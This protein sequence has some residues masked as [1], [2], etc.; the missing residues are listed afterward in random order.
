MGTVDRVLHGRGEVSEK[1]RERILGIISEL[2]YQP[3]VLASTLASK[4]PALFAT[5]LPLPLSEEGYWTK[6]LLGIK[7][8]ISEL[9]H[10]GVR[11]EIF[12]FNQTNSE[13][14]V[15]EADKILKLKPDGVV[16]APFFKNEAVHFTEQLKAEKIP[17]VFIDSEIENAGQIS[18]VGQNS[19]QSGFLSGKLIDQIV[20]QKNIL[21]V[22]FAKE[23]DNQNHLVLRERGFR[24]WFS[25]RPTGTFNISTI[26]I[27]ETENGTW[28]DSVHAV[29]IEKNIKGIFVTNSKAYLIC[30]L[31]EK[32]KIENIRLL[33]HDLLKWNVEYLKEGIIDYIISQ[34][35]EEQGFNAINKLFRNVVQK[36][37]IQKTN[38]SSIDI[39]TSENVDYYKE[40]SKS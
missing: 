38:Y 36:R 1:T 40:F 4:K 35:P 30:R 21:I 24:D 39:L 23:M 37:P 31:I 19:Y 18:Y 17:F 27:S 7:K 22:H 14:F 20:P 11:L 3:N 10:Y 29:I 32:H 15:T 5:L 13:S 34:K 16:L 25:K 9:R 12:S 33:G 28:M 2:N 8:R 26:E 6:P